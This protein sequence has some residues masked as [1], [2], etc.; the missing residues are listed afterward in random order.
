MPRR[1]PESLAVVALI[2]VPNAGKSTL[3]NRLLGERRALVA[4]IPGTT[5]DRIQA[6]WRAEGKACLLCDTGGFAAPGAEPLQ[7]EIQ[8]QTR[9][10]LEEARVIVLVL[11]GQAGLTA[12][13]RD[14]ATRLRPAAA[15][16]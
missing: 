6:R 3:F 14:L 15:R 1:D 2:G 4:D 12:G 8:R 9:A 16:V 11:D 10:A 7:G 5:R 13:E